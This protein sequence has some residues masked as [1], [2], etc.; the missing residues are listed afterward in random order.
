ML[1]RDEKALQDLTQLLLCP[2]MLIPDMILHLS[3]RLASSRKPRNG[4]MLML[5]ASGQAT[6]EALPLIHRIIQPD[7][8]VLLHGGG[9]IGDRELVE[10]NL[11]RSVVAWLK[12]Q[13]MI[14]LPQSMFFNSTRERHKRITWRWTIRPQL[15]QQLLNLDMN[16]P[17]V[18]YIGMPEHGDLDDH[19]VAYATELF[20]RT[21][22][23]EHQIVKVPAEIK[24]DLR[25]ASAG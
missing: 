6:V 15:K 20:L 11:R 3:G 24:I 13:P 18:F 10:E 14:Q 16:L 7:N 1:A 8:L 17:T 25:L 21:N 5:H 23:P 2:A 4:A 12:N 9:I 19:A 22:L